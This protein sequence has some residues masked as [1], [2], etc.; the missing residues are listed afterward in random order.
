MRNQNKSITRHLLCHF[1][2]LV[3]QNQV[4]TTILVE[5]ITITRNGPTQ[6]RTDAAS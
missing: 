4:K 6:N 5:V 2:Q 1:C 3:T